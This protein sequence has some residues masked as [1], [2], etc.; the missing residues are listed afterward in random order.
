MKRTILITALFVASQPLL[1]SAGVLVR[2]VIDCGDGACAG[3]VRANSPFDS[4]RD[5]LLTALAAALPYLLV[6]FVAVVA[7]LL[8]GQML[9]QPAAEPVP[10]LSAIRAVDRPATR[11]SFPTVGANRTLDHL[12]ALLNRKS[13]QSKAYGAVDPELPMRPSEWEAKL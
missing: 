9:T 7:W 2:W 8:A 12:G 11:G 1:V 10:A 6:M 4:P 5:M 13:R 3:T